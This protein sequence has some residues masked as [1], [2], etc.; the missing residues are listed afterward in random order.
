MGEVKAV[1]SVGT[2]HPWNIAGAGLDLRVGAE[3]RCRVLT[4]IAAVS[5]QDESG[6]RS[7]VPLDASAIEAQLAAVP[8]EEIG[9]VRVGALGSAPA[10]NAVAGVLGAR[11][12]PAVIDPVIETSAGGRLADDETVAA[13]AERFFTLPAAIVTPNVREAEIFAGRAIDRRSVADAARRLRERG[14]RAVLIKGGHLDGDPVDVLATANDTAV[15][16]SPRVAGT[17]RG[18]GCVLAMALACALARGD[19]LAGAVAFARAFVRE[20]IAHAVQFAGVRTAY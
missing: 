4:V 18:T 7:L 14:A 15:F 6:V 13:I 20:K 19:T 11:A 9:A 5:A 2:T 3:L 1:L 12:I 10:V 16:E 17:M 8:W